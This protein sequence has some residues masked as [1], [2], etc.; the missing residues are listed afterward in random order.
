MKKIIICSLIAFFLSIQLDS[1]FSNNDLKPIA[2]IFEAKIIVNLE[3]DLLYDQYTLADVYPYR[4][5]TREFQWDKIKERLAFV[6]SLR[7]LNDSTWAILQNKSNRIG[8]PANTRDAK[9]DDYHSSTDRYGVS[10]N[11]AIPLF[12]ATDLL[13]PDRYALDGS[14]VNITGEQDKFLIARTTSFEGEFFI[15]SN[16][17]HKIPQPTFAKVI[18][19]DRKNQNISTYEKVGDVWKIR[20]M[21]PCTTGAHVP[22]YQKETP[23]GVFMIQMKTAK[24]E[25]YE[26]GSTTVI[27]GFSP[28]ASRF[29]A[30]GYIHGVPVNLPRTE[31][32]EWSPTLGTTPRSHMCVRN[33]T[34]HAKFIFDNFPVEDTVVF[35]IE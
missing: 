2:E 23:L 21:N 18:V 14:L 4:N 35:V 5:G 15:P 13:V 30:G 20:S 33:A 28:W 34:S 3:K 26:D 25:Y 16:Y 29:C 27:A 6:D 1:A 9:T 19:V 10:S 24:M 11:Q 8:R 17:I 12:L 31:I 32:I 7:V 22:P